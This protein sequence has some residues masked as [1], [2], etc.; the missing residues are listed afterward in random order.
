MTVKTI[1][2]RRRLPVASLERA[3]RRSTRNRTKIDAAALPIPPGS[4][5]FPSSQAV[6]DVSIGF[7]L[8]A[9]EGDRTAFAIVQ[10]GDVG[11]E[12]RPVATV[13]LADEI[14]EEEK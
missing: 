8:G 14:E 10:P 1:H 6:R 13:I 2:P 12:I 7:D 3:D 11:F 4:G 5:A 9:P